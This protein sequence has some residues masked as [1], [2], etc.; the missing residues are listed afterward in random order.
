MWSN[1]EQQNS[2]R[3][4][5]HRDPA[6]V[7]KQTGRRRDFRSKNVATIK[8]PADEQKFNFMNKWTFL[9]GLFS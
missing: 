7:Y 8:F 1:F 5:G 4:I 2:T 3:L 9:M 6:D